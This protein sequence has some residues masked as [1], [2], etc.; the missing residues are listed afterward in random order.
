MKYMWLLIVASMA[1]GCSQKLDKQAL[2]KILEENPEIIFNVID[3][4]PEAFMK[5]VQMASK[6]IKPS[7]PEV[8]QEEEFKNPKQPEVI[9]DL[10][11]GDASAPVLIVEYTDFECP[12]CAR[13]NQTLAEI[14]QLYGPQV[15][16][17]KKHLP[18]PMHNNA[19]AAALYYEAIIS[20]YGVV[21]A[22]NWSDKVF[23]NQ[24]SFRNGKAS[25]FF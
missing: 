3:K 16:F 1:V 6:K 9:S 14:K 7:R 8:S 25:D 5:T 22:H 21:K 13:G 2:V 4:H 15:K 17:I 20:E 10:I 18:L 12:F 23:A 19:K 11:V 24:S